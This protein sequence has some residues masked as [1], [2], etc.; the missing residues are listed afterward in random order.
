MANELAGN[1]AVEMSLQDPA[2][3][4]DCD[5]RMV[6][7]DCRERGRGK[8]QGD[9]GFLAMGVVLALLFATFSHAAVSKERPDDHLALP[10]EECRAQSMPGWTK[11]EKWVWKQI[12]EGREADLNQWQGMLLDPRDPDSGAEQWG[13]RAI[14]SGFVETILLHEPYCSAIPRQ[15]IHIAGAYFP[16]GANL[17]NASIATRLV[18]RASRFESTVDLSR[19]RTGLDVLLDESSFRVLVVE[20]ATVGGSLSLERAEFGRLDMN[21]AR[22]GDDLNMSGAVFD[23]P[24]HMEGVSVAGDLSMTKAR[25][26]GAVALSK[27]EVGGEFVMSGARFIGPFEL[28]SGTIGGDFIVGGVEE[29]TRFLGDFVLRGTEV[30]DQLS[31]VDVKFN[32]RF[33]LEAVTTGGTLFLRES[34]LCREANLRFIRVGRNLDARGGTFWRVDLTS[35]RVDGALRLGSLCDGDRPDFPCW[36]RNWWRGSGNRLI[37]QN[38]RVGALEDTNTSWPD[39]L[40]LDGFT[41]ERLV[42][43]G[44]GEMEGRGKEGKWFEGWLRRNVTSSPQPYQ[45]LASVLRAAG[46]E[47]RAHDVLY[48]NSTREHKEAT[49]W[50]RAW[51]WALWLFIGYGHG[52]R[53]FVALLWAVAL[54]GVGRLVL[55]WYEE[56]ERGVWYCIDLVIPVVRLSEQHYE[57]ELTTDA[58]YYFY[59]H[60]ILGYILIFFVIG[61]LSGLTQ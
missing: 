16:Q 7:T 5:K 21:G 31:M 54:V 55:W 9:I 37:L 57:V 48:A 20:A 44:R 15:G 19:L 4:G 56:N 23:G 60:Q 22:V 36:P 2:P 58:K 30:G 34:V 28:D 43:L 17:A 18:L 51:L 61:G 24:L 35:S 50:K 59:G 41:Y 53:T 25:G 38:T 10:G 6:G 11:Q 14:S 40:E 29:G 46:H 47:E 52:W 1:A 3:R 12:C 45:Q 27:A 42:R 8:G 49:G 32:R 39:E 13:G 33:H 26:R